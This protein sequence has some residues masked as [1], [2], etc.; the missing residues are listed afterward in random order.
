MAF[1]NPVKR[2]GYCDRNHSCGLRVRDSDDGDKVWYCPACDVELAMDPD[3]RSLFE[4]GLPQ[5]S[6]FQPAT[7]ALVEETA[8][9]EPKK[10]RFGR[11]KK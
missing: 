7:A 6:G 5:S 3:E 9:P 4:Q 8:E 1:A 10:K 11:G 2:I